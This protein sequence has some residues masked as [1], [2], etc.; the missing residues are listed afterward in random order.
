MSSALPAVRHAGLQHRSPG[1][2]S[3]HLHFNR[4][5]APLDQGIVLSSLGAYVLE[6]KG[7]AFSPYF[8]GAVVL[9]N[10]TEGSK[11]KLEDYRKMAAHFGYIPSDGDLP[12]LG[13]DQCP[14]VD[15][16]DADRLSFIGTPSP[17]RH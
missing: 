2:L 6:G 13:Q 12:F 11:L 9:L 3:L 7:P 17:Y 1:R 15:E 10:P 16:V 4:V 8:N 5:L 14:T